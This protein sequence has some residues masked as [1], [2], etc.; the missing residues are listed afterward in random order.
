M[1][2]QCGCVERRKRELAA[3]S[4]DCG[5]KPIGR[6]RW[7]AILTETAEPSAPAVQPKTIRPA[8]TGVA[9]NILKLKILALVEQHG[10]LSWRAISEAIDLPAA[11]TTKLL[12]ELRHARSI[13]MVGS[14]KGS[15]Y[16]P[17][18][19]VVT[20]RQKVSA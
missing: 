2:C 18:S 5:W 19:S 14:G 9:R 1:P 8:V 11:L 17:V 20:F 16:V 3:R 7:L 6:E 12:D 4:F 15:A 10:P 13:G